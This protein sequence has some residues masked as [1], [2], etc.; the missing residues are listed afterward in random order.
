MAGDTDDDEPPP[1][2]TR[3]TAVAQTPADQFSNLTVDHIRAFAQFMVNN[4]L[5]TEGM[6]P[7]AA[8]TPPTPM[9]PTGEQRNLRASMDSAASA[10][11]KVHS[12]IAKIADTEYKDSTH[13]NANVYLYEEIRRLCVKFGTHKNMCHPIMLLQNHFLWTRWSGHN[14]LQLNTMYLEFNKRVIAEIKRTPITSHNGFYLDALTGDMIP[15]PD[16]WSAPSHND[17]STYFPGVE[18]R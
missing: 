2:P 13:H 4:G 3:P 8:S 1:L 7:T 12:D 6:T 10:S 11:S 17:Q 5:S 9:G 14:H 16:V 18:C 15:C